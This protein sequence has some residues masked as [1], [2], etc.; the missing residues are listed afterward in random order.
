M[1]HRPS[2]SPI[3]LS[4]IV[5]AFNEAHRIAP[6]LEA[7]AAALAADGRPSELLVVDDGSADDTA[8][9]VEALGL[10]GLTVH[11]LPANLGKGG[12]VR[13]GMR[14]ATGAVR[15]MCD[16]DGSMPASELFKLVDPVATGAADVVIG[17]RYVGTSALT[18]EQPAWRRA[19][20]KAAK[21][22]T[23]RLLTVEVEDVHCGYKAFSAAAAERV[24]AEATV[25]GWS[26][27]VEVLGLA[28]R[29]GLRIHEVGITWADDADS[30]V[31]PLRDAAKAAKDYLALRGTLRT[32]DRRRARRAGT[33][34][35]DAKLASELAQAAVD[36][37][38]PILAH[39][40][41]SRRCNLSCGYCFEYDNRSPPI[42]LAVLRER[43]GHLRRLRA[44]MVNLN[45]G[46]P[47][48]NPDIVDV[49]AA[50]RDAGMI[51]V[52]NS[53]GYLLKRKLVRA[54]G[55]AGLHTLQISVDNLRPNDVTMKSLEPLT[56]KLRLLHNEAA[57]RV[58]INTV[59]GSGDPR[60]AVAVAEAA[61]DFGFDAKVSFVRDEHGKMK[62][63]D[64]AARA[65][66]AEIQAMGRRSPFFLRE[67][68]M[69]ALHKDGR[70]DWK[71]RSGARYFWVCEQG[72]VHFCE[73]SYG[74]PG[75]PLADYTEAHVR[76]HFDMAKSCSPTCA[77]AYAHQVSRVDA[78]RPQ[79]AA[80]REVRKAAWT[81]V[82]PTGRP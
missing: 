39:L 9:V 30:R 11:R 12:A 82:N 25:D 52:M 10:P 14:R 20:S 27:D 76:A 17:S 23:E 43:I 62:P 67:D 58:R 33:F 51:P 7:L 65:A 28:A 45:G 54:L 50:V 8:A 72:L 68:F 4:V 46:E 69:D 78:W 19:W 55:D 3:A 56:P 5:P 29:A 80:T 1:R 57:F 37:T 61:I 2:P 6:T 73:S 15:V 63:L 74:D 47:L 16:A 18:V 70:R 48:L 71:C 38:R 24:F 53:N 13:A 42:P 26:F 34:A 32:I 49:V 75:I 21:A 41:V 44:V 22:L 81:S 77:V 36:P 35:A 79:G 66:Y 59:L 31:D 60:E 64:D 40:C